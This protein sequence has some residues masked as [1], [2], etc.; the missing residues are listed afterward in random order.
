[1]I[2]RVDALESGELLA[3]YPG[4]QGRKW[5]ALTDIFAARPLP[6]EDDMPAPGS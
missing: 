2:L 5:I 3:S 1:M 6:R 4:I